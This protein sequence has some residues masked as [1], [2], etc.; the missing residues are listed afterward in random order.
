M[1]SPGS[2]KPARVEYMFGGQRDW[3]PSTG[4]RVSE[5]VLQEGGGEGAEGFFITDFI[6]FVVDNCHYHARVYFASE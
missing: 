5:H 4:V 6:A 2:Q 1:L 3:R